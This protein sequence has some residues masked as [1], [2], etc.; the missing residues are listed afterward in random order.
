MIKIFPH[1]LLRISGGPFHEMELLNVHETAEIL[2]RIAGEKLKK[3]A[4][5]NKLSDALFIFIQT[6]TDSKLQNFLLNTRRDIFNNRKISPE[7]IAEAEKNIP[8]SIKKIWDEYFSATNVIFQSEA[9]GEKCFNEELI[10]IR[11]H[12]KKIVQN[13]NLQKGLILS[14]KTLLDQVHLYLKKDSGSL[15]KKE[16][17]I[18][19]GLMKY[20]T[21]M[22]TKTSPFSTFT[23]LAIAQVAADTP[24][25]T[26]LYSDESVPPRVT[27]H[28]RLNNFIFQY[29]K[30]LFFKNKEIYVNFLL[31]PNPTT[32][33]EEEIYI[34][35]TNSNNI[36]SFQ[37]I[38]FSEVLELLINLC[39]ENKDGII[40]KDL[41][42]SIIENQYI[43]ASKEELEE[44]I[45]QLIEYGFFE[46]N[47]GVSGIDPDWD[48]RIVEKLK[49]M[50][51]QLP[52]VKEL[53]DV[54]KE[55]REV[56]GSFGLAEFDHRKKFID[57]AYNKLRAICMKLHEAAGLP[58][59]ERRTQEEIMEEWRQKQKE[60]KEKKEVQEE[61]K[62]KTDELPAQTEEVNKE[63]F[64]FKHQHS[65]Y[66][67]FKPEQLF[68]EDTTLEIFPALN[69][70]QLLDFVSPFHNL[71]QKMRMY[72]GYTH[73]RFKMSSYFES[74]Y[75]K[76]SQVDL[77][78]FYEDF[79]RD[80]KKAEL[81]EEDQTRKKRL[82]KKE[83][84]SEGKE[85]NT[86][87]EKVIQTEKKAAR[88]PEINAHEEKNKL[89]QE[90]FMSII[91]EHVSNGSEEVRFK[92]EHVLKTHENFPHHIKENT[93]N[94]H[95]MFVQFFV[96]KNKD[97]QEKLMGV[98]NAPLPG[99]GKLLSRFLHVFDEK[100][101]NDI[102]QWNQDWA[103]QNIFVEDC[104]ASVFNANLHPAL[105]PYETWM[106]G[107]QNYLPS[108]KHIPITDIA[109]FME[110]EKIS[111]IHKP[112]KKHL[113]T[114]DLGFQ[115]ILG[116]SKLFQLLSI[117]SLIEHLGWSPLTN[118]INGII[119]SNEITHG[120]KAA[121]PKKNKIIVR[122]RIL[123]EENIILQ[124]K[125]WFIPKELLPSR[126][127][128]ENDWTYFE[129]VNE[130][131]MKNDIPV[132]V[133]MFVA[134]RN[135]LESLDEEAKK[136]LGKDDYKPQYINFNNP[137]L[138]NLFEKAITKVP[139][140]LKI[141]EMLP[142]SEHLFQL[143]K[144]KHIVE[145]MV[146]WYAGTD[147]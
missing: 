122:P 113:Y 15:K 24:G 17:Q 18:E 109:V 47:I 132:E 44:Y 108:D 97:G 98:V 77:L 48:I 84:L 137:L 33:K 22:Y 28:I 85:K 45:Q 71:L 73:E 9:A 88:I 10:I 11:E 39:S 43:D 131:R 65:T 50:G 135:T 72:E 34:F 54:L 35:L 111:L 41:V 14:S 60:E 96:E 95:A 70:T 126:Q 75:Q 59:G 106:P 138:I 42:Q 114:F 146:Q 101:T 80:I 103:E 63:D 6:I 134:D 69:E 29:L 118:V 19:Q 90:Q 64:V 107:S 5:K 67:S 25:N 133:F 55:I 4:L 119:N 20:I 141:E 129:K 52:L 100:I 23:N 140:T 86:E 115:G 116:R 32:R 76:N 104:D 46:Y 120:E 38:P 105:M 61:N 58:A 81:E 56:A 139:A 123:F 3:E 30:T 1:V 136:K 128:A 74:R 144:E 78:T 130:W 93:V 57:E 26:F 125:M 94:S 112:S 142:S 147:A 16:L 2:K 27:S 145:F 21:R 53:T 110:G 92:L 36:E 102:R 37:R 87:K 83:D 121:E 79:Y 51:E 91:K 40:Y 66:F 89:W 7:K 12:F 82:E 124:R 49:Q 117:F 127:P 68:Y 31:R 143:G 62:E 8:D 99:F 13:E